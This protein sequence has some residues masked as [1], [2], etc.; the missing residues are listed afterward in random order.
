MKIALIS[1][2][3]LKQTGSCQA[4]NMYLPSPLFKKASTYI[5]NNY[6]TWFI[7]SAK[8]GLLEPDRIIEPYNVTLNAFSKKEL[9]EWSEKV[10]QELL[11]YSITKIDFFAGNKYR[12]KLIPLLEKDGIIC[13]IP[14]QGL[15][16][17]QQLHYY[18]ER[19]N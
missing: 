7:L 13:N 3:K 15:G 4:Q 12:S 1:C 5:K 9:T 6:N 10:Y 19:L 17:G 8:Y 14:L 2:T 11:K 18:N 16:I